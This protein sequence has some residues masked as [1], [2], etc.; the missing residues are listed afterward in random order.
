MEKKSKTQGYILFYTSEI[1]QTFTK[2]SISN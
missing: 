2:N 1:L